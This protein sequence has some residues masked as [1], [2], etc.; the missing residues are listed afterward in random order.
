MIISMLRL[1]PRALILASLI[2]LVAEGKTRYFAE[3]MVGRAEI[4]G[5]ICTY[6]IS[7]WGYVFVAEELCRNRRLPTLS[8]GPVQFAVDAPWLFFFDQ[9]GHRHKARIVKRSSPPPPPPVS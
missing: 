2:G 8:K 3:G 6:E 4:N 9:N 7:G 5:R 1:V